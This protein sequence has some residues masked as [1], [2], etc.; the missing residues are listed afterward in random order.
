MRRMYETKTMIDEMLRVSTIKLTIN[1][2]PMYFT[3]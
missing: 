3:K 1:Q 2:V